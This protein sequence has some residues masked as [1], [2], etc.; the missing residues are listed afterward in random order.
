MYHDNLVAGRD[1]TN[2]WLLGGAVILV[3]LLTLFLELWMAHYQLP[4]QDKEADCAVD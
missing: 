3:L 1:T 4:D 2:L